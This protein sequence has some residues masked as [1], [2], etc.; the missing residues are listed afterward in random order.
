MLL[1]DLLELSQ[2]IIFCF[3]QVLQL[4]GEASFEVHELLSLERLAMKGIVEGIFVL[5]L[6]VEH[7][8][9][10]FV[11]REFVLQLLLG[12][13]S[14]KKLNFLL[15]DVVALSEHLNLGVKLVHFI[16]ILED[17][18]LVAVSDPTL[19]VLR[20]HRQAKVALVEH[21]LVMA[22]VFGV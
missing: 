22:L 13:K 12:S 16:L 14:L 15:H 10:E 18:I 1:E 2:L 3:L 19:E 20:P 17:Q 5:L 7:E 11:S 6:P 9:T 4:P 21:S 8:W